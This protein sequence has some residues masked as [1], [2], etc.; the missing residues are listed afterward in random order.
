VEARGEWQAALPDPDALRTTLCP[1]GAVGP[2]AV[3]QRIG[4][5]DLHDHRDASQLT[6]HSDPRPHAGRAVPR[7]LAHLARPHQQDTRSLQSLLTPCDPA[8]ME[9]FPVS[10]AVNNTRNDEPSLTEPLIAG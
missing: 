3:S 7:G 4:A 5:R 10:R 8:L 1:R 6:H 2:L 9:V